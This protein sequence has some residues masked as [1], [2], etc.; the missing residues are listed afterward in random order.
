[1]TTAEAI[2]HLF[3]GSGAGW[4]LWL[5][6]GLSFVGVAIAFERWLYG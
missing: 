4:V 3:I 2:K 6:A 5:L 1:M